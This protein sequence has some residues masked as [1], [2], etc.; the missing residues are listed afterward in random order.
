[1]SKDWSKCLVIEIDEAFEIFRDGGFESHS[2]FAMGMG[3]FEE[4][5][6]QAQVFKMSCTLSI[7]GIAHQGVALLRHMNSDLIFLSGQEINFQQTEFA[8]FL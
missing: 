3:D 6:V 8:C 2:L 5:G 7:F 1:M 4:G